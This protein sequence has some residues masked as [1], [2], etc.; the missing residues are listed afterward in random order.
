MP[1]GSQFGSTT[2]DIFA[3]VDGGRVWTVRKT[4]TRGGKTDKEK[5]ELN[6]NERKKGNDMC[7][8][9]LVKKND[10]LLHFGRRTRHFWF[11]DRLVVPE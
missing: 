11:G 9:V 3:A 10:D 6:T 1:R 8:N 4:E 2:T 7:A 5:N